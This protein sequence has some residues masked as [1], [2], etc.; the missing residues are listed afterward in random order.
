MGFQIQTG[1]K[2][3]DLLLKGT[4]QKKFRKF[5][6]TVRSQNIFLLHTKLNGLNFYEKISL[7]R[8]LRSKQLRPEHLNNSML[9]IC[10]L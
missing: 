10:N 2:G 3:L 7:K 6:F 4:V 9:Y 1:K 8:T 5:L